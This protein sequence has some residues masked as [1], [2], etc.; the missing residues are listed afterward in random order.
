MQTSAHRSFRPLWWAIHSAVTAVRPIR[1]QARRTELAR[2]TR[3]KWG[4]HILITHKP[5]LVGAQPS[6]VDN[7]NEVIDLRDVSWVGRRPGRLARV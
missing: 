2:L 3:P 1:S 6:N 7:E 4:G 5:R